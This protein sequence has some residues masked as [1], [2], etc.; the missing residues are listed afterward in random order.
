M[1][2]VEGKMKVCKACEAKGVTSYMRYEY[3]DS[4]GHGVWVCRICGRIELPM[5]V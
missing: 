4:V 3:N 5:K 1:V 2:V